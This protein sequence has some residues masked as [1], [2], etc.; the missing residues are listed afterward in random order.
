MASV[1]TIDHV[2][3]QIAQARQ[4][5]AQV[6]QE[7]ADA[8]KKAENVP[9]EIRMQLLQPLQQEENKLIDQQTVL[10]QRLTERM[11]PLVMLRLVSSSLTRALFPHRR[12]SGAC[13]EKRWIGKW[14]G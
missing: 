11:S 7:I 12:C 8:E 9:W 4:E 10:L 3:A 6:R 1:Q 2:R 5:T 14:R 13:T